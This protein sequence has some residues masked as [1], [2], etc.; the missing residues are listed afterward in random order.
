MPELSE[1]E[2][3]RRALWGWW[4]GHRAVECV[5]ADPKLMPPEAFGALRQAMTTT[6]PTSISRRGKILLVAFGDHGTM[7]VHFRM[8]G[9]ISREDDRPEGGFRLAWALE[10]GSWLAFRD[11]RR[12]GQVEWAGADESILARWPLLGRMGPEP[13]DLHTGAQLATLV[14]Q[15]SRRSLKGALLDQAVIAGV[16][17][18]A[19][20]ELF[21]RTGLHPQ[22]R[23][24][25]LDAAQWQALVEQMPV[26]FDWLIQMQES[27]QLGYLHE[28]SH[29]EN[30]FS[31]YAR[32]GQ[33]CVRCQSLIEQEKVGGRSTYYCPTCQPLR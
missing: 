4:A 11:P 13:H 2:V 31:V 28:G 20:S 32:R 6:A 26:Y 15:G 3:S 30:P 1:V 18:I 14:G 19:I 27:Q 33:P 22:V 25:Q 12:F 16:G 29:V 9:K 10:N 24:H 5:L 21:W 8:T 7:M 17:N 23:A